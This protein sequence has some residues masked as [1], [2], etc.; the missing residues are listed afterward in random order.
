MILVLSLFACATVQKDQPCDLQATKQ[1]E[2][3]IT[4]ETI[5]KEQAKAFWILFEAALYVVQFAM[6]R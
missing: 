1:N 3:E 6:H 5:D 2:K 4:Q